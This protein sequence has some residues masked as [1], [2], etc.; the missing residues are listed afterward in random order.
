MHILMFGSAGQ[1]ARGLAVLDW[2][3]PWRLTALG[4]EACDL[5][6]AGVA[7]AAIDRHRPDLVINAA[8]YTA[9]D[10]AECDEAGAFALNSAAPRE[11]AIATAAAGIP[12]L[13]ISTDYVFDGR[14]DHPYREADP[15]GPLSVYGR[16]KLEGEIQVREHQPRHVILRTSWVFSQY[17]A[18]FLRTMLRLGAERDTVAIV[19]DQWGG[20]TAAD[21]IASALARIAMSIAAG[22]D[23]FGTYHF[24]GA[25][26]TSWHGFARAI[27]ERVAAR[28]ER[29]PGEIRRIA[30][31]EYPTPAVR[32][33]NSRLDCDAIQRDWAIAR[34]SWEAALDRCLDALLAPA[35]T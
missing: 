7:A 11:M 25:P 29:V 10:K 22:N 23:K 30:T 8:A 26:Y 33:S 15:C 9:V 27:F 13:H 21:D 18:N 12:L 1:V 28:G 24:A 31:S 32:P 3:Q 20:P 35:R 6:Q 4:R 14:G 2:P 19:G 34:P 5:T 16:S 17:G